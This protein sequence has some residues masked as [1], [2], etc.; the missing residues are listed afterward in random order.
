MALSEEQLAG[1]RLLIKSGSDYT[2]RPGL[3]VTALTGVHGA[4][5]GRT[6]LTKTAQKILQAQRN[7]AGPTLFM[8]N[9]SFETTEAAIRELLDGSAQRRYLQEHENDPE[10]TRD[11]DPPG[12]GIKKIRMGTFED[13][14]KCKGFAFVDFASTTEA[15]QA[16]LEPR[17]GRLLGRSLQLEY[18]GVDAIRRGASRN[19][20]PDYVPTP[21]RRRA[22]KA[23]DDAEAGAQASA[24]APADAPADASAAA[25]PDAPDVGPGAGRA[26]GPRRV[27]GKPRGPSRLRPGAANAAAPRQHYAIQP[28]AGKRITF[29]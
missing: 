7:P 9:L 17:N 8:G 23:G 15:T 4:S 12:A 25:A 11:A 24:D 29:E 19:L 26:P 2:G 14:G 16:L 28:A 20:L 22:H 13:T 18:A 10:D 27:P 6:G 3:D 1:R 5:G 21:R